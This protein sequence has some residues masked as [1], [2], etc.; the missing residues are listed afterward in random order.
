MIC[1]RCG[2][3]NHNDA[4]HDAEVAAAVDRLSCCV[5]KHTFDE[6]LAAIT[7]ADYSA[8]IDLLNDIAEVHTYNLLE[9]ATIVAE[10][11][12]K[13][14]YEAVIAD[15]RVVNMHRRTAGEG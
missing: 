10:W 13:I 3:V 11:I 8:A 12:R 7:E 14:R 15:R 1:S 4:G 5:G 9:R 2:D 6:K